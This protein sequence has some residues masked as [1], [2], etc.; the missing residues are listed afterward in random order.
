[1]I[2]KWLGTAAAAVL[3]LSLTA[4]H[5]GTDPILLRYIEGRTDG[6]HRHHGAAA[7]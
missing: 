7:R 2:K 1:M 4:C 3:L 5:F 6:S